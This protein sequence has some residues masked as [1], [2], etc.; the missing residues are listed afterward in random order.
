[1]ASTG[2]PLP[3]VPYTKSLAQIVADFAAA[4]QATSSVPLDFSIGSVFL[5][6]AQAE[7]ANADW[8]Q[9]L[10]LFALLV[11][12]LQTSQGQWVDTWTADFMPAQPGTNSPR[13]P[14]S[15][16]S[17]AVTFTSNFPQSQRVIPV[18]TLVATYNASQ[19]YQ[20]YADPTNA[21]Y[22][23]TIIPGGGFIVP[24]GQ[25][26]LNVNVIAL[27]PGT[28]G[29][30]L[31][32]TITIIQSSVVGIDT[33]TNPAPLT[34]GLNEESD[35]ALKARFKLFIAS[36]TAGTVGAIEYAVISLQQGLQVTVH[37]NID[38]NGATDYGAV[39]VYVD[40]GSGGPPS[41]LVQ[42]ALAAVNNIRAASVRPNVLGASTLAA[43]VSMTVDVANGYNA[44]LVIAA[45]NNA[46]GA[47]VNSLGLENELPYT[48]LAN[49]A[50][51]A[52]PGVTNVT[53]I[54]LNNNN[55]DLVPAMGQTIKIG[56]LTVNQG[57]T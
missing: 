8:M 45:V 48:Q 49:V 38:P 24:A 7:G 41:S 42:S 55:V 27:N 2:L 33:V 39:T 37:E 32:N 5:A 22:S 18:G 11:S 44:Q 53:S 3:P 29:N 15:A 40:N 57:S 19:V 12:R 47:Y 56:S 1:M 14:A 6:L 35:A 36:L 52:S 20:V 31:A 13:L 34:T 50:Y 51:Q 10:Y 46:I 30:V 26:S 23:A 16:A 21:A 9:K 43:N 17:G 25:A 4:A 54:M 28:G